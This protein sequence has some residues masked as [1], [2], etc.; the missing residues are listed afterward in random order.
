MQYNTFTY[1]FDRTTEKGFYYYS[2]TFCHL[3]PDMPLIVAGIISDSILARQSY[4]VNRKK[5][6]EIWKNERKEKYFIT[7]SIYV[8]EK[9]DK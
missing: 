4:Y 3:P 6:K 5:K 7:C 2:K 8:P 9:R 1:K